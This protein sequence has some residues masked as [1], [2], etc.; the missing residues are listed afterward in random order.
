[1]DVKAPGVLFIGALSILISGDGRFQWIIKILMELSIPLILMIIAYRETRNLKKFW[2]I[3]LLASSFVFGTELALNVFVRVGNNGNNAE[4]FGVFFGLL[5]LFTI[6]WDREKMSALRLTLASLFF[7]S[8]VACKEPFIAVLFGMNIFLA[9][10]V[11][12]IVRSFVIPCAVGISVYALLLATGGYLSSYLMVD[13]PTI[14]FD[15]M[16]AGGEHSLVFRGF[17]W[18]R[19]FESLG[20]YS[21]MGPMMEYTIIA[22]LALLPFSQFTK[23]RQTWQWIL[24][25]TMIALIFAVQKLALLGIVL[26]QL[27]FNF[28]LDNADFRMLLSQSIIALIAFIILTI[29]LIRKHPKTVIWILAW[30]T[31]VYCIN[32][33]IASGNFLSQHFLLAIPAWATLFVVFVA[34]PRLTV[35]PLALISSM[36]FLHTEIDFPKRKALA[37]EAAYNIN[38]LQPSAEQA[39]ALMKRCGFKQFYALGAIAGIAS[40]MRH[41]PTDQSYAEFSEGPVLR[42]RFIE[43]LSLAPVI[44]TDRTYLAS[45]ED[46]DARVILETSF[47]EKV[48][49]C[50]Q[51]HV[52]EDQYIALFRV[53]PGEKEPLLRLPPVPLNI[54]LNDLKSGRLTKFRI[55]NLIVAVLTQLGVPQS[56]REQMLLSAKKNGNSI[57]IS[58]TDTETN[59][60][61]GTLTIKE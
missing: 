24:A 55:N 2:R 5:Y 25:L 21:H 38:L 34:Q 11:R 46:A 28:P 12:F 52:N 43:R 41:S 53:T 36:P 9:R 19:I 23:V 18:F 54:F 35:I 30:G 26:S 7:A 56:K 16:L 10:D 22:L 37:I 44:F 39:D 8:T 60:V 4:P 47:T 6:A 51:D 14:V 40:F 42:K 61:L 20:K 17:W 48:P 15:R 59:R 1:M 32:F 31:A 49:L 57:Q 27:K 50:A 29:T 58:I 33:A 3:A 13:I 45:M